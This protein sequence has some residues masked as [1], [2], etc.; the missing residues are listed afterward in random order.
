MPLSVTT[1]PGGGKVALSNSSDNCQKE[2]KLKNDM[3]KSNNFFIVN[4]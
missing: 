4:L 3:K 1:Q 2:K